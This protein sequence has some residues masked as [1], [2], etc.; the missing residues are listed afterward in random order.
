MPIPVIL[1]A[2]AALATGAGLG[3]LQQMERDKVQEKTFMRETLLKSLMSG[4][5]V[6]E[7]L[8]TTHFDKTMAPALRMLGEATR[9]NQ[10]RQ[11]DAAKGFLG[12]SE[13]EGFPGGTSPQSAA[14][15]QLSG[16]APEPAAPAQSWHPPMLQP[17]PS[18]A[19]ASPVEMPAIGDLALRVAPKSPAM[20]PLPSTSIDVGGLKISTPGMSREA[21][22]NA[23]RAEFGFQQQRDFDTA[24]ATASRRNTPYAELA[25][26]MEQRGLVTSSPQAKDALQQ[27]GQRQYD[28]ALHAALSVTT[29][30]KRAPTPTEYE[31][32]QWQAFGQT[33]FGIPPAPNQQSMDQRYLGALQHAFNA[34][35]N[36][37]LDVVDGIVRGIIGGSPSPQAIEQGAAQY[38]QAAEA[39]VR[40]AEPNANPART[41]ALTLKDTG[42]IGAT[43]AQRTRA[44]EPAPLAPEAKQAMLET[45][46]APPSLSQFAGTLAAPNALSPGEARQRGEAAKAAAA[47][48]QAAATAAGSKAG[49][50]TAR[51][52]VTLTPEE[53]SKFVDPKTLTVAPEGTKWKDAGPD[54]KF[55][56]FTGTKEDLHGAVRLREV[57]KDYETQL[58]TLKPLLEN[59]A[60]ANVASRWFITGTDSVSIP[61]T[62]ISIGMPSG[63]LPDAKAIRAAFPDVPAAQ[64]EKYARA[65]VRVQ[66][67][68]DTM[69]SILRTFYNEKGN[70][71]G[72]LIASGAKT[73]P[74]LSDNWL[75]A[76]EKFDRML[77]FADAWERG[78]GLPGYNVKGKK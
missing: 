27:Y 74:S 18:A 23:N 55:V 44:N 67:N 4:A 58:R 63:A 77:E 59:G 9:V 72:D 54:G 65:M 7:A 19:P 24:L 37:P 78:Y 28:G 1:G 48:Q 36:A 26:E 42:Y 31:G 62:K 30:G 5:D 49:A 45:G 16:P 32:A 20:R 33:G 61:G 17:A 53:R 47:G 43:E 2:L 51:P 64:A 71:R 22:A 8:L 39:R 52:N 35:P 38:R 60:W 15:Q 12:N 68:H 40:S 14:P 69:L 75:T 6:P 3:K 10:T 34:N 73:F 41:E 66:A 13:G 21:A 11:L 56:S 29:G 70:A 46:Q 25:R 50:E 76:S 57:V